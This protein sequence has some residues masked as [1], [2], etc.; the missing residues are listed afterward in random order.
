MHP[1]LVTFGGSLH[2]SGYPTGD[3]IVVAQAFT[4]LCFSCY[5]GIKPSASFRGYTILHNG[6][7]HLQYLQEILVQMPKKKVG[8]YIE[9][10]H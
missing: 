5:Y 10:I 2:R 4:L 1:I 8:P 6:Q 9:L 3:H 7:S